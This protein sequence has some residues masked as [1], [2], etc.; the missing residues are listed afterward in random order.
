MADQPS[1]RIDP[2]RLRAAGQR[3][4]DASTWALR[5]SAVVLVAATGIALWAGFAPMSAAPRAD[6]PSLPDIENVQ[7]PEPPDAAARGEWLAALGTA[8]I[9]SRDRAS[10]GMPVAT[11]IANVVAEPEP[12]TPIKRSAETAGAAVVVHVDD[13]A[14]VDKQLRESFDTIRLRAIV[15]LHEATPAALL[16]YAHSKDVERAERIA[17]GEQFVVPRQKDK[18]EDRWT[19]LR[20]DTARNRIYVRNGRTTL[21]I[22][23]FPDESVE[24][25]AVTI[26]AAPAVASPGEASVVQPPA[27]PPMAAQAASG[28]R[29]PRVLREE[30]ARALES[31]RKRAE[32][33]EGQAI[34]PDD[35][36][37]LMA[38]AAVP[39]EAEQKPEPSP[40]STPEVPK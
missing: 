13:P 18:G 31:I 4:P 34:T 40:D 35:L 5:L 30:E 9:F 2:S 32:E 24:S 38:L 23:L 7:L 14:T 27:V 11:D 10:W 25:G 22:A 1:V 3:G 37:E 36:A 33:L 6:A 16:S 29:V 39:N 20:V 12:A 19:L 17:E 8:H 21:G 28:Q 15:T 26:A